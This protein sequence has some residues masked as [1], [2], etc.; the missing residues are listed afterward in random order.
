MLSKNRQGRTSPSLPDQVKRLH[1]GDRLGGR[2]PPAGPLTGPVWN[3]PRGLPRRPQ[4]SRP[5][6]PREA[7]L[8][9]GS[10]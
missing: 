9:L 3:P 2:S 4:A 8:R 1:P 7:G 10:C 6:G 5:W